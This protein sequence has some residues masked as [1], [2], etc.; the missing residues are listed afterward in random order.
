MNS[1]GN[2]FQ[3]NIQMGIHTRRP[4]YDVVIHVKMINTL[5]TTYMQ[6]VWICHIFLIQGNYTPLTG[7]QTLE[8]LISG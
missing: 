3:E 6:Y 8:I 1:K 4:F 5:E 7:K 2:G